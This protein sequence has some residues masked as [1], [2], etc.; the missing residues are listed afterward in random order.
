MAMRWSDP[1]FFNAFVLRP[2]AGGGLRLP[3]PIGPVAFDVGFNL[4]PDYLVNESLV[5]FF[6]T[7]GVL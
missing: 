3:S 6:L 4:N 2:A 7:I 5:Q 1:V